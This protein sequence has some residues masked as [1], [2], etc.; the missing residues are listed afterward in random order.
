MTHN[1]RRPL[2]IVPAVINI[3]SRKEYPCPIFRRRLNRLPLSHPTISTVTLLVPRGTSNSVPLSIFISVDRKVA[4]ELA[5]HWALKDRN[6]PSQLGHRN[7][8]VVENTLDYISIL[9]VSAPNLV[10]NT[11]VQAHINLA[12]QMILVAIH[13]YH[14][15]HRYPSPSN[16]LPK[17]IFHYKITVIHF[18]SIG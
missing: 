9:K 16:W 1:R 15:L 6:H 13:S 11:K 12:A 5:H 8:T 18:P 17:F 7:S 14:N 4:N 3:A 2:F 10:P